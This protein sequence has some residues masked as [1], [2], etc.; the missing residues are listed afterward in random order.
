MSWKKLGEKYLFQRSPWLTVREDRL[1]RPDGGIMES[2]YVFEYPD[3]ISVIAETVDGH[4]LLVHQY[5]HAIQRECYELPAGICDPEDPNPLHSAQRELLEETGYGG[6]TWKLMM[7]NSAN[8]G[9]HDNTTHC[10]LAKG[11]KKIADQSL[12]ET[13]FITVH[14]VTPRDLLRLLK[15]DHIYQ[16]LHAAPLWKY[17]A[18]FHRE[19]LDQQDE[20]Q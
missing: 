20:Q 6:G 5:R 19:L 16:S 13:E 8:P 2:Y 11:V 14:L 9:T 3:W 10:F 12:D 7:Q 15:D 17:F 4:V 18:T 1:Q